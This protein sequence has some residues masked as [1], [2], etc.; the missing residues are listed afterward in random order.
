MV[1]SEAFMVAVGAAVMAAVAEATTAALVGKHELRSWRGQ[2]R[3]YGGSRNSA[4]GG[5][6]GGARADRTMHGTGVLISLKT[7]VFIA[8]T[9][10]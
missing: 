8:T 7:C 5:R 10:Y 2:Q 9:L 4:G 1:A 6:S 3:L